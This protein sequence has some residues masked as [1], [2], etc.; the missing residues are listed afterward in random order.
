MVN[1]VVHRQLLLCI[2]KGEDSFGEV[3]T[4]LRIHNQKVQTLVTVTPFI[5]LTVNKSLHHKRLLSVA[6]H[7]IKSEIS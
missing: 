3:N 6:N 7:T 5:I 4:L 1:N 2:L